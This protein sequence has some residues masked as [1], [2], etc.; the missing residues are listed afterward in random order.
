MTS[1]KIDHPEHYNHGKI[2]A[3]AVIEDWELD[4]HLGNA[5]KYICRAGRKDSTTSIEDLEKASWYVKRK[6][7]LLKKL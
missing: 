1:S 4:F 2:E 6:I 3:I 5:V 7:K